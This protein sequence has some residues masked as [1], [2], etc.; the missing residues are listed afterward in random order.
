MFSKSLNL[1]FKLVN[2]SY[3]LSAHASKTVSRYKRFCASDEPGIL[4]LV[5]CDLGMFTPYR[6]TWCHTVPLGE[7]CPM[8]CSLGWVIKICDNKYKKKPNC[9]QKRIFNVTFVSYFRCGERQLVPKRWATYEWKLPSHHPLTHC[10]V[11]V[12]LL[13]G[14]FG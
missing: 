4:S 1:R 5:H 3:K 8:H 14:R 13:F 12:C 6:R 2:C 10:L 11:A 7:H 9:E